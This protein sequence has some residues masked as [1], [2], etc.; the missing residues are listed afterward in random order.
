MAGKAGGAGGDTERGAKAPAERIDAHTHHLPDSQGS[1][2]INCHMS[3]VNWRLITRRLDHTFQPPVPEMTAQ[4]GV[5]NACNGCHA[6]HD[7][8]WAAAVVTATWGPE[9]KGFQTYTPA[10]RAG[11]EGAPGA[12]E[13]LAAL[14]TDGTVPA[15]ARATVRSW[16]A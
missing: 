6:D 14:I 13:A 5:P 7:A 12:A 4:Y 9:R 16:S 2:C 8:A 10:L 15:I 1:R 11:R 3:D